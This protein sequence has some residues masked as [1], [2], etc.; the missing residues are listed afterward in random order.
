MPTEYIAGWAAEQVSKV[1]AVW[2]KERSLVPAGNQLRF[3]G[4]PVHGSVTTLTELRLLKKLRRVLW[5]TRHTVPGQWVSAY[6]GLHDSCS[7]ANIIDWLID[8]LISNW[9]RALTV[10]IHLAANI[11][12]STKKE[13]KMGGTCSA[14]GI[15]TRRIKVLVV[16]YEKKTNKQL[17]R[18]RHRWNGGT[19]AYKTEICC[20]GGDSIYLTQNR[21]Q[22]RG[23]C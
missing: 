5:P 9:V 21:V 7:F 1:R 6:V 4:Y 12:R 16:K 23:S 3:F 11:I 17:T 20:G 14:L 10:P 15:D 2:R 18:S 13:D 22:W 19:E 8:W